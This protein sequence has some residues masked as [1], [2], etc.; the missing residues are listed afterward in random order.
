MRE[1]TA[2]PATASG[3]LSV[4]DVR[5]RLAEADGRT[6]WRSLDELA[7][8]PELEA[9]LAEELPRE[10]ARLASAVDRREFLKLAGASLA[11]AGLAACTKQPEER[12]VPYVR[13]PEHVVPGHPLYYATA[14]ARR[15]VALGLL[16][17]SHEGRPTKAEGNPDHPGS[18]GGTDVASQAAVLGLY[19]PDRSQ[20]VTHVGDIRSW[21]TF[22]D[23]FGGIVAAQRERRGT[24]LRILTETVGSPTLADQL[25][26]LL[27][28]FPEARWVQWEPTATDNARAGARL[29][30]GEPVAVRLQVE[31]ADVILSLDADFLAPAPDTVRYAREFAR[32]RKPGP[33][34]TRLYVVEPAPTITGANADHR[35]ALRAGEVE[36]FARAVAARLGLRVKG[37]GSPVAEAHARWI[38]AV[39]ADLKAR[40][41]TALVVAG[42]AQPPAVHALAHA[43]NQHLGGA[44][45]TVVYTDPIEAEPSDQLAGITQLA[46]DMNQGLVDVLIV[47]GGN[48]AYTAPADLDFAARMAKVGLRI[49]HGL[50][51][52][53][54]SLLC[55]WHLPE[56]HFL[57]AWSDA[58]AYDGTVSIVQP[59]IAPLYEGRSAHELL[60]LFSDRPD[61]TG[62]DVVR[63]AWQA[64]RAGAEF[65][66]F[67]RKSLHDGVVEGTALAPKRPTLRGDW[68]GE[69]APLPEGIEIAFR[70][71]EYVHD[72]RFANNGWLQELDRPLT[73][74]VWDNAALLA[75]ATAERLELANDD[76]VEL[77]FQGRQVRAPV[78]IVPG[79]AAEAVTVS[80]GFGRTRAGRVGTGV[81]FDAYRLRTTSALHAGSRCQVRRTGDVYRLVSTQEHHSMEG[82]PV[83]RT[84]TL[85]EWTAHPEFARHEEDDPPRDATLYPNHEYR[86][87]AWGMAIDLNACIGCHAC[88]MACS[89]ENNMPIVGKDQVGRGRDLQWIRIDRY[90]EGPLDAPAILHQPVPCMHCENAPCEVVCPVNATVHSSEGLNEMVYNR[91]VGTRYCS[92]NCP[93]KVR[94]YNFYLYN[95]WDTET[96]KMGRNPDVTVRSRG[97]MEKCTYCVQ[98]IEYARAAAIREG[99]PIRDGDVTPACA[100][101]CPAEAIVFGD[102]NDPA[103]RVAKLKADSRNYGLLAA[104]NTRPRTTYLAG[105]RNPNPALADEGR[106]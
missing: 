25:R 91:C 43:M 83:V 87:Y 71:D 30:F 85:T 88:V 50:Y 15:G 11:L 49:R 104:L 101:A 24:G 93:Y 21:S 36:A 80:L 66:T 40:G 29:A 19:D 89:S 17:E 106:S 6:L 54:T 60:A 105:V 59:L 37:G 51:E 102:I 62:H 76:V 90:F 86:G 53:E 100:Q 4:A 81:G 1:P 5:R 70:P 79:H 14:I 33:G 39:A 23:A 44:G 103:S 8:M 45:R 48:P 56:T 38:D 84:A 41:G 47:I 68:D 97:V 7:A 16:V 73:K 34:M 12:I 78:W 82:R 31:R 28:D 22:R 52:D 92:N 9:F 64:R 69:P 3:R 20:A 55:H 18:L 72:G 35:L 96:Y 2:P 46:N 61:R 95:D 26:G 75:P 98:R 94:R 58:R 10:A 99:R 74:L 32:R 27:R 13:Q 67:W 57:E 65:E 42:D 63:D 77:A